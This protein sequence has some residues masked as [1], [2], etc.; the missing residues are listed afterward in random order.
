MD[1]LGGARGQGVGLGEE[2]HREEELEVGPVRGWTPPTRLS[3]EAAPAQ[4]SSDDDKMLLLRISP[5][6]RHQILKG[7]T[8]NYDRSF[9]IDEQASLLDTL[10]SGFTTILKESR[11]D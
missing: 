7:N 1:G 9:T 2:E 3:I 10:L 4:G 6:E 11:C 5:K 8:S